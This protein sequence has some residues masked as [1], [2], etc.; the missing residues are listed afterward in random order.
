MLKQTLIYT[1]ERSPTSCA[2]AAW[3]VA[4]WLIFPTMLQLSRTATKT[5]CSVWRIDCVAL[6]YM[7][8]RKVNS[9]AASSAGRLRRDNVTLTFDVLTPKPNQFIFSPRC[10][11]C[12]SL[13][14]IHQKILD[15]SRMTRKH[16]L[17]RTGGSTAEAFKTY[18]A[19][20]AYLLDGR[21]PK[22]QIFHIPPPFNAPPVIWGLRGN[23]VAITDRRKLE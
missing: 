18:I 7:V 11:K 2:N 15:I 6:R 3:R 14:E 21:G 10:F 19:S 22:M 9:T 13:V 17:G 1:F 16:S 12:K 20:G 4:A 8:Y 5:Y 23:F